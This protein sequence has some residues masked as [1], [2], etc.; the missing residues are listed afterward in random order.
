MHHYFKVEKSQNFVCIPFHRLELKPMKLSP[1]EYPWH[2]QKEDSSPD[3]LPAYH[4]KPGT[5]PYH[6]FLTHK[7]GAII[8]LSS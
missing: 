8:A 7:M 5:S 1:T 4:L 2:S 3:Y 6:S